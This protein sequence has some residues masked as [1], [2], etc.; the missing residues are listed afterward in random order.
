MLVEHKH[1]RIWDALVFWVRPEPEDG[2]LLLHL[3]ITESE[4]GDHAAALVRQHRE[5]DALAFSEPGQYVRCVVADRKE[6][7]VCFLEGGE[8][9]LQFDQ[10]R[11]AER[12]PAEGALKEDQRPP[13]SAPFMEIDDAA[14]LIGEGHVGKSF[15]RLGSDPREV[16]AGYVA[17]GVDCNRNGCLASDLPKVRH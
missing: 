12:S 4:P 15:P 5:G 10:L 7:D 11:H 3:S 6:R 8:N 9:L 2:M 13:P 16:D 1:A 17:P 14:G